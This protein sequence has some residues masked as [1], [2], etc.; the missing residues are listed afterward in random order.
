MEHASSGTLIK[1][2]W[3]LALYQMIEEPYSIGSTLVLLAW[4]EPM[5]TDRDK[6]WQTAS[7]SWASIGRD[8]LIEEISAE[9]EH[10]SEAGATSVLTR[11][12]NSL[13][14]PGWSDPRHRLWAAGHDV[15]G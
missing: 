15:V 5:G 7:R 6:Y 10:S 4:L 9:F 8:D 1:R 13:D 12:K 11:E 3:A 2:H 14:T